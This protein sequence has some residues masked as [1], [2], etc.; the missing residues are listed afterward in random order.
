MPFRVLLADDHDILR[1]GL[2]TILCACPDFEVCGEAGNGREAVEQAR[3]LRPDLV[4]M[5]IGMP[6]LNGLGATRQ[7]LREL[8]NIEILILTMHHSE[9]LVREVLEAGARGYVLKSDAA[10]ELLT[11]VEAL[12]QHRLWFTG[13]VGEIVLRGYLRSPA[14]KIGNDIYLTEREQEIVQLLVEGHS[15]KEVAETLH[16]SVKTA[17]THRGHIMAKLNLRSI[18]E[19]VRYAVRIGIIEA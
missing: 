8:P 9:Y 6:E 13:A 14:C 18:S 15:N 4:I 12:A 16:I 10:R 2:R 7:I 19:L 3:I 5:D 17:E 11:A 1:D